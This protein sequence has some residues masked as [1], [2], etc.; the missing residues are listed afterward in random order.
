MSIDFHR[1]MLADHVRHAAFRDALARTIE[2]GKTT[3]ADIGAGTGVLA[4][5]A[6]QLGA[7]KVWLYEPGPVIGLTE[8]IA[9]DNAIDGI[10]LVQQHSL[11]VPD[12]TPVDLVVAEV[13]GNF[14]YEE[15]VLD[16]LRDA[17]RYLKP[18]GMLIPHGIVQ[19]VAPVVTSRF[20][21]ELASWRRV[22]HGLDFR[23]AETVTRN[24]MYVYAIE[25]G[26][27]MADSAR[28]W[29]RVTFLDDFESRREG[30]VQWYIDRPTTIY[31][32]ALW[33]TC[34]L[35]PGVELSTSP[36]A[37]RTHWDQIYLPLM[38]PIIADTGDDVTLAIG[39]ETSTDT[40]GIAVAW[41]ATHRGSGGVATQSLDIGRG[42]LG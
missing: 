7:Q 15:G 22:G 42:D 31:G 32:F 8:A 6:R 29:D 4:F 2:R 27:L 1:R 36:Y 35:T 30:T 37:P 19:F 13:L 21:D 38:S 16:T 40:P 11:D 10:E 26:D 24:N 18:G 3:V 20:D 23:S 33:W 28:E 9:R 12:P 41:T 5:F 25:P 17:R 34:T 14:A 39:T